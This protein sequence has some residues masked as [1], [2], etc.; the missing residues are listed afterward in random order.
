MATGSG[1][2]WWAIVA[3]VGLLTGSSSALAGGTDMGGEDEMIDVDDEDT[4]AHKKMLELSAEGN[5]HYEAGR[6]EQAAET[7][8]K[9]YDTY[10]QPILL[11]NQMITR[12]LLDECESA[13]ELGEQFL[14]SEGGTDEQQG[15]I[16]EVFGD[17]SY[18]LAEDAAEDDELR[19]AQH[20][21]DYGEDYFF[22]AGRED[23]ADEL[24]RS[25][26]Q[27]I[28]DRGEE[29]DPAP[30]VDD[31]GGVDA[32]TVAG[33]SLTGVGALALVGA[34]VWTVRWERQVS[35]AEDDPSL[36]D[37]LVESYDTARWAV[38]TLYGLGVGATAA[39]IAL[40]VF[41]SS[42]GENPGATVTPMWDGDRAGARF[43]ISF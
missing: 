3:A 24:R 42:D 7:Y 26:E 25:V 29:I 21:L 8:A 20:W 23:D 43:S 30:T 35:D 31:E 2:R 34:G 40:L 11:K 36:Y 16:Q 38:P 15:D 4:D 9:A 28:A 37:D 6:I 10:P 32:T 41:S 17:C 12:Y 18:Q 5:E 14:D 27:R 13:I 22:E 39:G 33:W 19:Q 1:K